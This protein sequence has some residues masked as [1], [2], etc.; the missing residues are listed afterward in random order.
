ML[1]Q[2]TRQSVLMESASR[3]LRPVSGSESER[4]VT[5]ADMQA[6]ECCFLQKL[7][8][9][10]LHLTAR[11]RTQDAGEA[12]LIKDLTEADKHGSVRPELWLAQR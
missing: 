6:M 12:V 8:R 11:T 1:L 9:R 10:L 2:L 3:V 4:E 7:G 5:R